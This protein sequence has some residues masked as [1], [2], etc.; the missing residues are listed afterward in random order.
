MGEGL[1]QVLAF[2]FLRS[3]LGDDLAIVGLRT[4]PPFVFL[5]QG[6]VELLQPLMALSD[7]LQAVAM[8]SPEDEADGE[9]PR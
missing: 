4:E 3:E 5:L 1:G 6:S 8:A 7:P 9:H 2:R